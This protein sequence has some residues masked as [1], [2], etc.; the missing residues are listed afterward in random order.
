MPASLIASVQCCLRGLRQARPLHDCEREFLAREFG[1]SL[2]LHVLR[3]CGGG[4]PTGR[5]AWQPFG[6]RIQ[7]HD[8]CFEQGDPRAPLKLLAYPTFAHEALHVWQRQH[9]HCALNVSVDGLWLGA[10]RGAR[11]YDYDSTIVDPELMLQHFR[12]GNIE[13]QGRMFED[14]VRSN[15]TTP[16]ARDGRF[17]EV[18]RYVRSGACG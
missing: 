3:I 15:I 16:E 1:T 4:Q 6:A 18:A 5:V 12:S 13:R 8:R 7:M 10:T 2:A 11:A 17:S 14:Y 9:R